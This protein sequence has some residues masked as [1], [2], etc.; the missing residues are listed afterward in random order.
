MDRLR[1]ALLA[2]TLIAAPLTARAQGAP[3]PATQGPYV[4]LGG[5]YSLMQDIFAHPATTPYRPDDGRYR[6]GDGYV[7][8]GSAGWGLGNGIRVEIEIEGLYAASNINNYAGTRVSN[9]TNGNVQNYGLFGNVFYDFDLT[10]FGIDV[11]AVRPYAGVGV[12]VLWT[13]FGPLQSNFGDGT[14]F[15][16]GGT[17]S[18]FEYQGAT[19]STKALSGSPSRS[20]PYP[21][22]PSRATTASSAWL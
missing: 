19:S 14:V 4:T 18:N 7:G 12:G 1:T 17:A 10:K 11:T 13:R 5:G 15:R 9:R 20:R 2:T 16:N 22:C 8:A 3:L 6:F 21:A